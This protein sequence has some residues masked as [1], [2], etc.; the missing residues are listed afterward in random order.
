MDPCTSGQEKP[1]STMEERQFSYNARQDAV[2]F[3]HT[4]KECKWQWKLR[5]PEVYK[6]NNWP[7]LDT[8]C[9]AIHI[10]RFALM[11]NC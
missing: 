10:P 4:L 7:H 9:W 1:V 2:V 5:K 11:L 8:I 3:I 6:Q